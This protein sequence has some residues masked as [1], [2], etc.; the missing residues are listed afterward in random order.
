MTFEQ[1]RSKIQNAQPLDF[2]T[3]FDSSINLYKQLWLQ[4]FLT[5]IIG[6]LITLP[7][8]FLY[9]FILGMLGLDVVNP[10][11]L[12]DFEIEG[13]FNF[14]SASAIYNIPVTIISTTITL[15]LT[16]AF[17]RICLQKEE[18]ESVSE[19]Y[20]YFFKDGHLRKILILS[21]A[22]SL[23]AVIAQALCFIPY[24]YVCVPLMFFSVVFA[25]NSE[26]SVE[27]IVKLSFDIGNKKWLMSFGLL[28]VT[29]VIACLGI[30][31]CGIGVLFTAPLV[32][33]PAYFIYKEVVGVEEDDEI[34]RIGQE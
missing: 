8:A 19:D 23:V 25:F 32:Y 2:G 21:L 24:I 17:Y 34:M 29:G 27:E 26:K 28:I 31:A 14:Y 15:A 4:G 3:I 9:T 22:Y 10:I 1:L 18:G 12:G 13:M 7:I 30:L 5:I 11:E 33:F 6:A 20:F 16:S